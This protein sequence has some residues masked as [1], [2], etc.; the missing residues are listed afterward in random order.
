MSNDNHDPAN[1]QF[2]SGGGGGQPRQHPDAAANAHTV[3]ANVSAVT[4]PSGAL[5]A[6]SADSMSTAIAMSSPNGRISGRAQTAA[7]N[8]LGK[9]LFGENGL[10]RG[11][12]AV[13][14][15]QKESLLRQ[16]QQFRSMASS[17]FAT[18]AGARK[19][20]KEADRLERQAAGLK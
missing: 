9:E 8:Q 10:Q 3:H 18:P 17:R 2:S 20:N 5:P 1:G 13:Q 14:P 4:P 19:N 11:S 12:T 15:T 16:A 6:R 7:M